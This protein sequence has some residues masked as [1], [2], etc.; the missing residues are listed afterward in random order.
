MLNDSKA[1]HKMPEP[2]RLL[3]VREVAEWLG[4]GEGTIYNLRSRGEGPP[5]F[6]VGGLVKYDRAEVSQ[7]L[8]Q[9]REHPREMAV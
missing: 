8:Q 5:G 1:G 6:R 7:W 4:L 9:Q 3:S 2:E